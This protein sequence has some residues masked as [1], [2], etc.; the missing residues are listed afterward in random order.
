MKR[1]MKNGKIR[2]KIDLFF[3]ETFL[4]NLE[5]KSDFLLIYNKNK[6]ESKTIVALGSCLLSNDLY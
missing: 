5:Q 6:I 3:F 4:K 1:K 2:K